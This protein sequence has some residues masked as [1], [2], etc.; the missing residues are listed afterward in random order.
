LWLQVLVSSFVFG[1]GLEERVT[2]PGG[3]GVHHVAKMAGFH[4]VDAH[5]SQVS[6]LARQRND[7]EDLLVGR[8]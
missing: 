8:Q 2:D 4:A 3:V 5:P 1:G 6:G 7:R